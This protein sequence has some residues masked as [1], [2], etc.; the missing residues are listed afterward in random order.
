MLIPRDHVELGK[1]LPAVDINWKELIANNDQQFLTDN[2]LSVYVDKTRPGIERIHFYPL[3][4]PHEFK[5]GKFDFWELTAYDSIRSTGPVLDFV[6]DKTDFDFL[7][8]VITKRMSSGSSSV[9]ERC[10][11]SGNV[12]MLEWEF[13]GIEQTKLSF[14]LPSYNAALC[15]CEGAYVI[16]VRDQVFTVL[17]FSGAEVSVDKSGN[18]DRFECVWNL[19]IPSDGKVLVA[20]SCGYDEQ[21]AV[22]SAISAVGNPVSVFA[23]AEKTWQDY[24]TKVVLHFDCSN[25]DIEKLYYYAAWVTRANYYDIPYEPFT[26]PYTSPWKTGALWQ[27]SWNTPVA[28]VQERWLNDKIIGESGTLLI[29][30]NGG[31]LN[32]GSYLHP[33]KKQTEL[34]GH[35]EQGGAQVDYKLHGLPEHYDLLALTTMAHT[36]PN[37]MLNPWLLY[38]CSGDRVWMSKI[39]DLMVEA[40][41]AFSKAELDNG[42]CTSMFIDDFDYSLRW[43]PFSS[44]WKPMSYD[45]ELDTPVIAVDYNCYL[46]ALRELIMRAADELERSDIDLESLRIRNAKLK[47]AIQEYLWDDE[48]GFYFDADPRNMQRSDLKS[49]AAFSSLCTGVADDNQVARLITHLTDPNEFATPY[50]CPSMS[51]DTPGFDPAIMSQGGDC[52]TTTGLWFTIDGLVK[53]GYRE[54]AGEYVGKAVEM[55]TKDGVISACDS[56]NT[57]TGKPNRSENELPQQGLVITDLICRYVLGISPNVDGRLDIDPLPVPGLESVSSSFGPYKFRDSWI[58]VTREN[59]K[60]AI[61]ANCI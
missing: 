15:E 50:P 29:A 12:C 18:G 5:Y 27:W 33:L 60:T 9:T 38:L 17:A 16:N 58:T 52:L 37:G 26:R 53:H 32:I 1:R 24:F 43:K 39:L 3:P 22:K 49:I 54:L 19:N 20:V 42:F 61:D 57:T 41:Q 7:P 40:E 36:T 30:E 56:H 28:T 8:N 2:Q 51:C 11:V 44:N 46:Y 48:A 35:N 13:S 14:T 47:S 45:W 55:M 10:A 25:R 31:G 59:G 4:F 21:E 23:S 34:R 6:P